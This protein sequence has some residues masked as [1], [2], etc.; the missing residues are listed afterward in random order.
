MHYL[1]AF[2]V[3]YFESGIAIISSFTEEP[4]IIDKVISCDINKCFND[5]KVYKFNQPNNLIKDINDHDKKE[6]KRIFYKDSTN[7][8][9]IEVFQNPQLASPYKTSSKIS[10]LFE[11]FDNEKLIVDQ[12]KCFGFRYYNTKNEYCTLLKIGNEDI[13]FFQI[14]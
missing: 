14:R 5:T 2:P 11:C 4:K 1:A 12:K 7:V 13:Y 3:L 8:G 10:F 6:H 9:Y